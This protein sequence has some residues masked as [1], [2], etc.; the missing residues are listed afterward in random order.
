MSGKHTWRRRVLGALVVLALP[1]TAH[2]DDRS[3]LRPEALS[4]PD[5]PGTI[6]GLGEALEINRSQG[7]SS[8][9]V[10]IEVPRGA[11]G[12]R[13]SLALRY[14]SGAAAGELGIGW[15]LGLP[16]IRRSLRDGLPGYTDT[17]RLTLS[18]LAGAGDLVAMPDGSL[19]LDP[20]GAFLRVTAAREA[21]GLDAGLV[22]QAPDGMVHAFG[23]TAESRVVGP[24]G[25]FA[26]HLSFTRDPH[27][28]EIR[29]EYDN[30]D[31]WPRLVA[32][33]WNTHAGEL[34]ASVSFEWEARPDALRSW[35]SGAAAMLEQRVRR[36]V[37]RRGEHVHRTIDLSYFDGTGLSRLSRVELVGWDGTAAP[38]LT[39]GYADMDAEPVEA[40]PLE[41]APGVGL[42]S[43]TA[44]L[45]DFDGDAL[46]DLLEMDA[47][48]FGGDYRVFTRTGD[49]FEAPVVLDDVP[50]IWL[51]EASGDG[52]GTPHATQLADI[53]GDAQA[54]I[55]SSTGP[56]AGEIL[57]WFPI[58]DGVVGD[59]I[60]LGGP[61]LT[62]SPFAPD[63]RMSD[64]DL[65]RRPDLIRIADTGEVRVALGRDGWESDFAA[66]TTPDASVTF[67]NPA[68][69]LVD[70][71]AD[72]LA[73]LVLLAEGRL[74]WYAGTGLG[75]FDD[76]PRRVDA[77]PAELTPGEL[78]EAQL[79]DLTGDGLPDLVHVGVAEVRVW[80]LEGT[81]RFATE[82]RVVT[83]LPARNPDT[84]EVRLADI[85]GNGTTDL[86][87][88]DVVEPSALG[89]WVYVDLLQGGGPGLLRRVDNGLG[90]VTE[91]TYA[92]MGEMTERARAA[93]LAVASDAVVPMTVL[94][95]RRIT[96]GIALDTTE[97]LTYAGGRYDRQRHELLGF[98]RVVTDR[99]P[100]GDGTHDG[101]HDI[102][103]LRTLEHYD[104]GA[105]DR[106]LAGRVEL[107]VVSDA[108]GVEREREELRHEV[109]ELGE[110]AIDGT[111]LRR[112]VTVEQTITR[113][114]DHETDPVA[115]T[116]TE[117]EH[118]ALGFPKRVVELGLIDPDSPE[119]PLG[120]DETVIETD[121]AHDPA[122]WRFGLVAERRVLSLAGELVEA[123]RTYYDGQPLGDV[124]PRALVTAESVWVEADRWV[125]TAEYE[126]DEHGNRTRRAGPEGAEAVFE[127]DDTGTFL[128]RARRL[129]GNEAMPELVWEGVFDVEQGDL[130]AAVT[131]PD[132]TTMRVDYDGLGRPVARWA[133]D[134]GDEPSVR[135]TYR[136][137]SPVSHVTTTKKSG[138]GDA[139]ERAFLSG[140]GEQLGSV[141]LVAPGLYIAS[142]VRVRNA[143]G[144][145]VRSPEPFEVIAEEPPEELPL[146][147]EAHP[148]ATYVRDVEGRVQ[149]ATDPRGAETVTIRGARSETIHDPRDVDRGPA[150]SFPVTRL[151]DGRGRLVEV[152]EARDAVAPLVFRYAWDAAD[153]PLTVDDAHGE[154][155]AALWDGRG[156]RRSISHPSF[157]V[158]S[159]EHDEA[160]R[161]LRREDADG[162]VVETSYDLLG[163]T[164]RIDAIGG[165]GVRE[166]PVE[167]V[168]DEAADGLSAEFIAGRPGFADSEAGRTAWEYDARGRVVRTVRTL[169]D[170]RVFST[171]QE[172]DRDDNPVRRRYPDGRQV[173]FRRDL[174]GRVV[175]V[176]GLLDDIVRDARGAVTS[177]DAGGVLVTRRYDGAGLEVGIG[178]DRGGE[179]LV[180]LVRTLDPNRNPTEVQDRAPGGRGSIRYAYDELDRLTSMDD[181]AGGTSYRYDDG[182][183]LLSIA[184]VHAAQSLELQ[185]ADAPRTGLPAGW[186]GGSLS[187]SAG[188]RLLSDGE[189]DFEWSGFGALT[190]VRGATPVRLTRDHQ[191]R[192]LVIAGRT[193]R[194]VV[195]RD[196]RVVDGAAEIVVRLD[197]RVEVAWR[198]EP[199][200]PSGS[201]CAITSSSSLGVW[202]LVA[203]L[204]A[205]RRHAFSVPLAAAVVA[206]VACGGSPPEV[207]AGLRTSV[208][209]WQGSPVASVEGDDVHRAALLP[210]GRRLASSDHVTSSHGFVG[211]ERLDADAVVELG[212][213]AYHSELG[214]FLA[215]DP[216]LVADPTH[217]LSRPRTREVW[218]YGAANPLRYADRTGLASGE[219]DWGQVAWGGAQVVGGVV[220]IVVS[221]AASP[222]CATVIACGAV[223][224]GI[225]GGKT[226]ATLGVARIVDGFSGGSHAETIDEV[227]RWTT[228]SGLAGL[229]SEEAA[230]QAGASPETQQAVR[231]VTELSTTVLTGAPGDIVKA[232]KSPGVLNTIQGAQSAVELRSGAEA[233][234]E[235]LA[236][237]VPHALAYDSLDLILGP[238]P[239]LG[240]SESVPSRAVADQLD[241]GFVLHFDDPV[242]ILDDRIEV[243]LSRARF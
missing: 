170:G 242:P 213:R 79:A 222:A 55:L 37:V 143:L 161:E 237:T 4:L 217:S 5:G 218:T 171:D 144:W 173:R 223:A 24:D 172:W 160:G 194:I 185:Y 137:G 9:S 240:Q 47:V 146:V 106:A 163:R 31:N 219:T 211:A 220:A 177:V 87:W 238:E 225:V 88:V 112:G 145:D 128:V 12:H 129:T 39:F 43:E 44:E 25:T 35:T 140:L 126:H 122:R 110:D 158:T 166:V 118:D 68:V 66:G 156:L 17:D 184:S 40:R 105:E 236:R 230:R 209:D 64:L 19:R 30:P 89:E 179:P 80:P 57:R 83:E 192:A 69:K 65:D 99:L 212:A 151:Y 180:D 148:A 204:L 46:P 178:A 125:T 91:L 56:G 114:E 214:L 208:L 231:R 183:R 23:V 45:V 243:D 169:P 224:A 167:F 135:Y 2:A 239:T 53:D 117:T 186:E 70:L 81:D 134:D 141:S 8:F 136:H 85:N 229:A 15:S 207:P 191:G 133:A 36:I 181:A 107:R 116:R 203:F 97:A 100:V 176:E 72:G 113:F 28:H 90:G 226:S 75:R 34:A 152:R 130:L 206:A 187:W 61:D 86:L 189:R 22:V 233:A 11:G 54:D 139:F 196:Y 60:E 162:N 188:G 193:E 71:S 58:V 42:T 132:G 127:H 33:H 62:L 157:G 241:R 77:F 131:S 175:S 41:D 73:D 27:G 227:E 138:A 63:V 202:L 6:A 121:Y 7:T 154:T 109:V 120:N 67:G 155:L 210:Y 38:P 111:S 216:L 51:G 26:W 147:P 92:G 228:T 182:G 76:T 201:G 153:R 215:P 84:T 168:Y 93:G 49:G 150:E 74:T 3:S 78:A 52:R 159:F 123:S 198:I 119:T 21:E 235:A 195:S 59:S 18:G 16:V 29:Y 234:A 197:D 164:V 32:I 101:V 13:P 149:R 20:E 174:A 103:L 200:S 104:V 1:S 98:S 102:G 190:A 142:S 199:A 48:R 165:D 10:P 82:P 108:D 205:L 221:A 96:D 232:V 124:G 94:A 95:S 50:S 14:G 115:V